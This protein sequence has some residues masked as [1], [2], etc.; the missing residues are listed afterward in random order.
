[1]S[2]LAKDVMLF[3]GPSSECY[4][5]DSIREIVSVTMYMGKGDLCEDLLRKDIHPY[6][7]CLFVRRL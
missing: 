1:M 5:E 4:Y 2:I 6:K 3:I 7:L